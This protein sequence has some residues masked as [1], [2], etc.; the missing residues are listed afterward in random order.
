MR[1]GD[2]VEFD[3]EGLAGWATVLPRDKSRGVVRIVKEHTIGVEFDEPFPAGHTLRGAIKR[4]HG[5]WF[6]DSGERVGHLN[7]VE[8]P[9]LAV[10]E[11]AGVV[12]AV[13]VELDGYTVTVQITLTRQAQPASDVTGDESMV[14]PRDYADKHES[15]AGL[16]LSDQWHLVQSQQPLA[17][18]IGV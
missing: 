3:G 18:Y 13:S 6:F 9:K 12:K 4:P 15:S 7:P 17:L 16:V 11:I 1:I 2:V 10:H 8:E 5:R 14:S